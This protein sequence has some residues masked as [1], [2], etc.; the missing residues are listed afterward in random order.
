MDVTGDTSH[1]RLERYLLGTLPDAE[2]EHIDERILTDSQ[3]FDDLCVVENE[4]A[5]DYA[6]GLLAGDERRLF[7]ERFLQ[8]PAIQAR[9][10]TARQLLDGI[11]AAE[12]G[13]RPRSTPWLVYG[14]IAASLI[15]V[16][17]LARDNMRLRDNADASR[18]ASVPAATSPT[19][20]SSAPSPTQ[21]A[22]TATAAQPDSALQKS[23]P[24]I[25]SV[26]LQPGVVRSSA[27][28]SRVRLPAG[29]SL[30]LQLALPAG[31]NFASYNATLRTPDD[32][33]VWA[34]S[35]RRPS[36]KGEVVFMIPAGSVPSNDYEI[37]LYGVDPGKEPQEIAN[38]TVSVLRQ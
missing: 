2:R 7:E 22:P 13:D 20:A 12:Y 9:V 3:L 35:T 28:P 1:D 27:V 34:G 32:E 6:I 24:L 8:R 37:T 23:T 25:V 38:Y 17:W 30:R 18:T 31:S 5:Y 14:G 21:P 11:R 10:Q 15:L 16:A 26:S 36:D 4:L 19:Q 33:Q 29:A